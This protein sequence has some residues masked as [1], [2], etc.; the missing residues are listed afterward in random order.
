M[1]RPGNMLP[2]RDDRDLGRAPPGVMGR[3]SRSP[4][5]RAGRDRRVGP[6]T[7]AERPV[8]PRRELLQPCEAEREQVAAFRGQQCVHLVEDDSS[9]RRRIGAPRREQQRELLGRGQQHVGGLEA[10]ALAPRAG[11]RRCGSRP[12][13]GGPSRRSALEVA[14]DI[15][16][17]RLERRN[18]EGVEA[19]RLGASC[20]RSLGS[21][22]RLG[23]KPA[24]VLPAPVGAIS[25]ACRPARAFSI[26]AS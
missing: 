24:S 19:A 21:S 23:R 12:G 1:A 18:I 25:G 5:G 8:A 22:I 14:L 15:D 9:R 3:R 16:R 13:S 6:A 2:R 11:C 7:V 20:A 4:A 17:Q 10:L 26:I